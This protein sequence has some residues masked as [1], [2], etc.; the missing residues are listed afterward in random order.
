MN[1]P[2]KNNYIQYVN[3]FNKVQ[4]R[5]VT[6][7]DDGENTRFVVQGIK[8]NFFILAVFQNNIQVFGIGF[9][10]IENNDMLSF[11]NSNIVDL[12]CI[13]NNAFLNAEQV[14]TM[15]YNNDYVKEQKNPQPD[16]QPTEHIPQRDNEYLYFNEYLKRLY[17][18]DNY[19]IYPYQSIGTGIGYFGKH[20]YFCKHSGNYDVLLRNQM[21][22]ADFVTKSDSHYM[23]TSAQTVQGNQ[24][25][26]Q[27][28]KAILDVDPYDTGSSL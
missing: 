10:D 17:G 15:S 12:D 3:E 8:E 13:P 26:F 24:T 9:D 27:G 20:V 11:L 16:P 21:H 22:N 18:D 1:S 14:V 25:V 19:R 5:P 2:D 4:T 6:F 23:F 7:V 28:Y